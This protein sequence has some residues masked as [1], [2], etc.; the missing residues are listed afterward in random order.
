[1]IALSLWPHIK[2]TPEGGREDKAGTD[3]YGFGLFGEERVQIKYDE[4]IAKTG[5]VYHEIYEK[6]KG[7]PDQPWRVSPHY[8]SWYIFATLTHAWLV[9]VDVLARLEAGKQLRQISP[10]SMGFLVSEQAL[11]VFGCKRKALSPHDG[12]ER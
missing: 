11:A 8:A 6:T 2:V 1:M 3:G 10:S 4:T 7:R 9:P 12:N 5:N